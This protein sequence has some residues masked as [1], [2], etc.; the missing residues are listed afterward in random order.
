MSY[1]DDDH[2]DDC[3][4]DDHISRDCVQLSTGQLATISNRL[5]C[6]IFLVISLLFIRVPLITKSCFQNK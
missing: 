2:H 3:R 5:I 6:T 4:P 1:D